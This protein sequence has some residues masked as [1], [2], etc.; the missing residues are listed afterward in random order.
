MSQLTEAVTRGLCMICRLPSPRRLLTVACLVCLSFPPTVVYFFHTAR[1]EP[2]RILQDSSSR[3]VTFTSLWEERFTETVT[4]PLA[5]A[6]RMWR[7]GVHFGSHF[8]CSSALVTEAGPQNHA[9]SPGYGLSYWTNCP[10]DLT[11]KG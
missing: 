10:G 8:A 9:R 3:P 6:T 7:P 1:E 11:F 5:C 4:Q 2:L